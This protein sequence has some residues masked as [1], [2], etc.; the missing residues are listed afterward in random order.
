M[1]I[2]GATQSIVAQQAAKP[3]S[4]N[5]AAPATPAK[6]ANPAPAANVV[7]PASDGDSPSVE[8]AEGASTKAPERQ[9]GGFNKL[10]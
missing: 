9:H 5:A 4:G 10:V 8:A 6:S 3:S 2:S 1:V 7:Q